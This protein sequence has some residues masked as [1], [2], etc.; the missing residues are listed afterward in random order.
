MTEKELTEE[1]IN[2]EIIK[3]VT[4]MTSDWDFDEATDSITTSTKLVGD[5]SFESVEIVQLMVQIEQHFGLKNLASEKLLV[6][7][8]RAVPDLTIPEISRFLLG[9]LKKQ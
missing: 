4:D 3:I 8:G 5:L 1:G 7:D 9:E 2:Q 6:K